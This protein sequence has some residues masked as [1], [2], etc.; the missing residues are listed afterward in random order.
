M[1]YYFF[2]L[3]EKESEDGS[4][5]GYAYA[6][7]HKDRWIETTNLQEVNTYDYGTTHLVY[8]NIAYR[9]Q[10][11]YLSL[12]EGYRLYIAVPSQ[13]GCDIVD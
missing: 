1:R 3:T 4:K 7:K 11:D 10:K 5:K 8:N 13:Y 2:P 9:M 6:I 12:D